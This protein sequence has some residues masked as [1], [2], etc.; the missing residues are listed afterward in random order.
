MNSQKKND[1][2]LIFEKKRIIFLTMKEFFNLAARPEID[3]IRLYLKVDLK[4]V[5]LDAWFSHELLREICVLEAAKD[6]N[7]EFVYENGWKK[8]E[9]QWSKERLDFRFSS[10]SKMQI[11]EDYVIR[12]FKRIGYKEYYPVICIEYSVP[13]YY[14]FSNGI[15]RGVPAE[16]AGVDDFL[17]PCFEALKALN[18]YAYSRDSEEETN[19]KIRARFEIR[20]LDLSYNFH[21][22]DVRLAMSHLSSCILPKRGAKTDPA[23]IKEEIEDFE[24]PRTKGDFET[25]TFGGGKGSSYK[26]MFYDKAQE[27]K[28]L[29]KTFERDLSYICRKERKQWYNE[30]KWKF[31]NIVRFEIQFHHR[32][33]VY[34]I[35]ESKYKGGEK[36]AEN[37]INLCA[38]KW[39]DLLVKFDEQLNTLNHHSNDEIDRCAEVEELLDLKCLKGEISET[40]CGN[41]Q[42]FL[43]QCHGLGY[44]NV[45]KTMSKQS[46]SKKYNDLKKLTHF[47][48]KAVCLEELPIMRKLSTRSYMERGLETLFFDI[49]NYEKREAV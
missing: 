35:P 30:N 38:I 20:R 43:K 24:N 21:V 28:N 7:G 49:P 40:V 6:E 3:T 37:I 45:M 5:A 19:R 15:N 34:H 13:K 46:F 11:F 1:E 23:N 9:R 33:F 2:V 8:L 10:F 27:Q 41:L 12:D 32:F 4:A 14:N 47:D 16:L 22:Q 29:F 25:V 18:F 31:E 39:R 42:R 17:R 36:M 26:I 48:V 44:R